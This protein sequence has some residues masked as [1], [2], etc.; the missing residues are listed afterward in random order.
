MGKGRGRLPHHHPPWTGQSEGPVGGKRGGACPTTTHP[1]PVSRKAA[2]N[3]KR[4]ASAPPPPTLDR[5]ATKPLGRL[6]C[7]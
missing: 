1:G 5:V 2:L 7:P 4:G 6:A 3:G